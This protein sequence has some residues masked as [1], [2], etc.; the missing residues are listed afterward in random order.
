MVQTMWW[1]EILLWHEEARMIH[2]ESFG[3]LVPHASNKGAEA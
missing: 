1:D 3:L 2:R